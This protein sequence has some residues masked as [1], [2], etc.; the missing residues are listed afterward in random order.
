MMTTI[1]YRNEF[2]SQYTKMRRKNG[3]LKFSWP[4]AHVEVRKSTASL[5]VLRYDDVQIAEFML[6]GIKIC[7]G[8]HNRRQFNA[9]GFEYTPHQDGCPKMP[10]HQINSIEGY[11]D[12]NPFWPRRIPLKRS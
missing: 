4:N 10:Q 1:K 9:D 3:E 11:K 7:K 2:M 5:P 8:C 6:N 12:T